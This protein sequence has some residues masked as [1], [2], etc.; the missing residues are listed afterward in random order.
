[1][2]FSRLLMCKRSVPLVLLCAF[3]CFGNAACGQKKTQAEAQADKVR[4][5]RKQQMD[6]AAK[7]YQEIVTKYADS[8]FAPKAKERL[9]KLKPESSPASK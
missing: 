6:K 5:F 7:S 2:D 9:Q 8:E 1:M 3:V 4:A